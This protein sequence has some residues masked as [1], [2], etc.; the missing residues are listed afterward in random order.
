LDAIFGVFFD[1][2]VVGM[3]DNSVSEGGQR[4]K[5]IER[6]ASKRDTI[7]DL[8]CRHKLVLHVFSIFVQLAA[9]DRLS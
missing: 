4:R 3:V 7:Q 1:F 9:T 8:F 6:G 5:K 2:E